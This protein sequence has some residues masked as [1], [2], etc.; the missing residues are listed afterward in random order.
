MNSVWFKEPVGALKHC[1]TQ[2][3]QCVVP[4]GE[5]QLFSSSHCLRVQV[6][7]YF[8]CCDREIPNRRRTDAVRRF[9]MG[10]LNNVHH[11][12]TLQAMDPLSQEGQ[13]LRLDRFSWD[14]ANS[15]EES[16]KEIDHYACLYA[17]PFEPNEVLPSG[18]CAVVCTEQPP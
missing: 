5:A 2:K 6:S 4:H 14:F 3:S 17:Y 13:Y 11:A 10:Y 12:Q 15:A 16:R 1:S 9:D 18:A 7:A 8:D